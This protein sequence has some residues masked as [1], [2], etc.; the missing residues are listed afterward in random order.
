MFEASVRLAV[1]LVVLSVIDGRL[2]VLLVERGI[3]PFRGASALPGGFVLEK[4]YRR[5]SVLAFV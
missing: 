2:K 4:H 5:V 1:D 3:E